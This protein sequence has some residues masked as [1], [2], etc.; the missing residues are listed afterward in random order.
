MKLLKTLLI[1]F[2]F[3]LSFNS[4]AQTFAEH[5]IGPE[6]N[7]LNSFFASDID[8]DGDLDLVGSAEF[9]NEIS[10]WENLDGLGNFGYAQNISTS[11]GYSE[12]IKGADLDGDGDTDILSKLIQDGE[13]VWFKN[14]DGVGNFGEKIVL[15]DPNTTYNYIFPQD[16]DNDGDIDILLSSGSDGE[17]IWL[18]NLNGLGNFSDEKVIW[19]ATISITWLETADI[20]NDGDQD[21]VYYYPALDQ[22]VWLENLDGQGNFDNENIIGENILTFDPIII[23][24]LDNDGDQDIL[25]SVFLNDKIVWLKNEDGQGNFS[26]ELIVNDNNDDKKGI[27]IIDYDGDGDQ[28]ILCALSQLDRIG[29]YENLDGSDDF[30]P[31]VFAGSGTIDFALYTK[32]A[33]LDGDGYQDI[34]GATNDVIG[35]HKNLNGSGSFGSLQHISFNPSSFKSITTGDLDGDGDQDIIASSP[36]SRDM[37]RWYENTADQ[38]NFKNIRTIQEHSIFT[39]TTQSIIAVDF[40]EDNDLDLLSTTPN[41]NKINF[42]ENMDGLGNFAAPKTIVTT[43]EKPVWIILSDIDMDGDED[44]ISASS[45]DTKIA[46][47]EN[48]DGTDTVGV[49]N[50]VATDVAAAR[51]VYAA[52]FDQDGDNDLVTCIHTGGVQS[53]V[54]Y[55]NNGQG[56]FIGQHLI[57]ETTSLGEVI[58]LGDYDGDGYTDI[59]ICVEDV[60]LIYLKNLGNGTFDDEVMISTTITNIYDLIS[61]DLDQDGDLDIAC[62]QDKV[63]YWFNNLDGLGHFSEELMATNDLSNLSRNLY[64]DDLDGDGDLD[65]VSSLVYLTW[66]EN[67]TDLPS[68]SGKVFHDVNSNGVL[69]PDEVGLD[70]QEINIQPT[71]INAWTI[72]EG[73]FSFAVDS[74][75]YNLDCSAQPNWEFTTDQN[76]TIDAPSSTSNNILFGLKP[77]TDLYQG[78]ISITYAPT[79][80]GFTVPIWLTNINNGTLQ[81][82]GVVS[83]ELDN[84]VNFVEANPSPDS[85]NGN[86]LFWNFDNLSPFNSEKITIFLQMPGVDYIGDYI[87]FTS[88]LLLYDSTNNI[89]FSEDFESSSQINCAYDP[90]DKLVSPDYPGDINYTLFEETLEYTIRFQNTGTDTA[91]NVWI[92]DILDHNLNWDSFEPIASSHPY[93]V[94]LDE[95]G[96][97]VF[98]FENILLPDSTT[99]EPMSH[100]FIKYK[101]APHDN[102]EENTTI[103]N[104]A[105]IYFDFN[106]A[107]ITNTITNIM[108]SEYPIVSTHTPKNE[109]LFNIYPNPSNGNVNVDFKLNKS[110]HWIL[111]IFDITG[112][113]IQ[114]IKAPPHGSRKENLAIYNLDSGIY[115]V[116]IQAGGEILA[117]KL[118]IHDN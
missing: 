32:S 85:I 39:S 93:S 97:L 44:L 109:W 18:E 33:D 38:N 51:F 110:M 113:E 94:N 105:S 43:A 68:I 50:I 96:K 61:F 76:I 6:V 118:I 30:G 92:H 117:K 34:I 65:I 89:A 29:Y 114:K 108:V 22:I 55:E 58:D 7:N 99:N 14:L 98:S 56:N 53:L 17:I 62:V 2:Y 5:F 75:T 106:P 67:F 16:L 101:I 52:D 45:A 78:E 60:K 115:F 111:R 48:I 72:G 87:N 95:T 19:D 49:E 102:L 3:L 9:I 42:H 11:S 23:S 25:Y 81:N 37:I 15:G 20:D 10:W 13:L 24:D 82:S 63:L 69:D 47:Y 88:N 26:E 4:F 84:L 83:L 73:N 21:I 40:D 107:I 41:Q 100:G 31:R 77:I 103:L 64:F 104:T 28:D 1:T 80:C 46:W 12:L 57:Y 74:G 91:F 79:R 86:T 59:I 66:L 8:G 112:M 116:T 27:A 54:W 71:A 90:N 36:V 35:F 70:N